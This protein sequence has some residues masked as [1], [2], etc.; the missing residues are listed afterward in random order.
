MAQS[1]AVNKQEH[2][3][4]RALHRAQKYQKSRHTRT[5]IDVGCV[6]H[7]QGY[8][9]IYVERLYNMVRRNF[10]LPVRMHVWTEHDRSVPPDYIKH[11]LEEWPG[12]SG[13]KKSWWY[14][15]QMFDPSHHAGDLLYFDLDVVICDDL[16]WIL[17][18]DPKYFWALRDFRY[19]Q[20]PT[21]NLN[22][23]MMWWDTREYQWVWQRFLEVTPTAA[24]HR[25]HGDQDFLAAEIAVDRRRLFDDQHAQSWRWS[26]WD[27]GMD[28][29]TRRHRA[30]GTG[31]HIQPGTSL[32]VFHGRPK[33]HEINDPVIQQYWR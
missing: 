14:K 5:H 31:T 32:L 33:P 28:F 9:W 20:R 12:I 21:S 16:G 4:A 25:Y 2:R 7:G 13:P 15:L 29:R 19:L 8:E 11:C 1:T 6:L 30:P 3:R 10:S 17:A 24:A 23:S 22:S 26:A 18:A 27:G